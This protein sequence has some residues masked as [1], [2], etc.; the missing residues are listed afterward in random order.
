MHR[1]SAYSFLPFE[2]E[3]VRQFI[4][5]FIEDADTQC[6]LVAEKNN[7]IV[8]MLGGYIGDY[9]FCYEKV[10]YDTL[11]FVERQ[12][13]GSSAA[14]RLIRAFRQWAID[15]G[16]SEICLGI[17][18]NISTER[19]GMFYERMGLKQVGGIYKQRLR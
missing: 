7:V 18:T 17:S 14:A 19:T 6:G 10:A 1:E 2:T 13:R 8:G 16:A 5:S 4:V 12:N 9:F 15:S 11:L 3:K